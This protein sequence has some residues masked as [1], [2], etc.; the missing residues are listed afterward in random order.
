MLG[1]LI[2]IGKLVNVYQMLTYI[3]ICLEREMK[4]MRK[5]LRDEQV[6][7]VFLRN[8]PETN[9]CKI[10]VERTHAKKQYLEVEVA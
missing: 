10:R 8:L 7:E 5:R 9:V 3:V 4:N 6:S 1:L 2:S